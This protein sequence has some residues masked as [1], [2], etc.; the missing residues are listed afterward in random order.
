[1][2]TPEG[3]LKGTCRR[4]MTDNRILFYPVIV[5]SKGGCM[6]D[7]LCVEGLFVGVEYKDIGKHRTPRQV[8]RAE[9]VEANGGKTEVIRSLSELKELIGRVECT[10]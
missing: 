7:I 6:D 10:H 4:W 3:K 9:E 5:T 1:M 8:A 2:T